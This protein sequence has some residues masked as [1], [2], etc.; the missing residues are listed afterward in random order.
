[1][2]L[3]TDLKALIY[4]SGIFDSYDAHSYFG[5]N[6]E[7]TTFLNATNWTAFK[8]DGGGKIDP[9]YGVPNIRLWIGGKNSNKSGR[10]SDM[11][12]IVEYLLKNYQNGEII[13]VVVQS[14]VNGPYALE[15]DRSYFEIHLRLTQKR[16]S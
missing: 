10:Y 4:A 6:D 12:S 2:S 11:N 16:G 8:V 9:L 13:G 15:G 14:D 7:S 1:M 5:I 3:L